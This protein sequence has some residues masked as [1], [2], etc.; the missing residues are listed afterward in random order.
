MMIASTII[1]F[2]G[3]TE[4]NEDATKK[5]FLTHFIS[6]SLILI[7]IIHIISVNNSSEIGL[8][9]T[10]L[11]K[12]EKYNNILLYS[13]LIGLL[14]NMAAFPF[15]GWMVSYYHKASPSGFLYLIS[16]TTKV[17]LFLILKLFAGLELL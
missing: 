10:H 8:T 14:T 13:M 5:Y 1:I 16:F 15:C 12:D 11:I 2:I 4:K 17:S 3:N 9:I 7:G 6:S